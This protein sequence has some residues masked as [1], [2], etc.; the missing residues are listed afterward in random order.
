MKKIILL[1]LGAV[2]CA[3]SAH[4]AWVKLDATNFPDENF[5]AYLYAECKKQSGSKW[6]VNEN[7]YNAATNEINTDMIA[8]VHIDRQ[9]ATGPTASKQ[10]HGEKVAYQS[11]ASLEGIKLLTEVKTINLPTPTARVSA[12]KRLDV[13]GMPK[14]ATVTNG[15]K[16][17]GLSGQSP[18]TSGFSCPITEVLAENCPALKELRLSSYNSLTNLSFKGS[19]N[20][21]NLFVEYTSIPELDISELKN[22]FNE[23]SMGNISIGPSDFAAAMGITNFQ[24]KDVMVVFGLVGCK[25]LKK[26]TLGDVEIHHLNLDKCNKLEVLDLSGQKKLWELHMVLDLNSDTKKGALRDFDNMHSNVHSTPSI[27]LGSLKEVIFGQKDIIKEVVINGA[28]MEHIDLD[29]I[30]N[31]VVTLDLGTNRL[32]SVDL[33]RLAKAT[34]IKVG[35]NRIRKIALPKNKGIKTLDIAWNCLTTLPQFNGKYSLLSTYEQPFEILFI[36]SDTWRVRVFDNP[37]DAQY[38]IKETG[39]TIKGDSKHFFYYAPKFCRLGDP[40]KAEYDGNGNATG[41]MQNPCYVYFFNSDAD[42]DS[43]IPTTYPS[44]D[45]YY[46]FSNTFSTTATNRFNW[47]KIYFCRYDTPDSN[48]DIPLDME[49]YLAG[50]FNNWQPTEKDKFKLNDNV[51]LYYLEYGT[52]RIVERQFRVWGISKNGWKLDA[53]NELYPDIQSVSTAVKPGKNEKFYTIN[54]MVLDYGAHSSETTVYPGNSGHV[55][56]ETVVKHPLDTDKG[57][58]FTTWTTDESNPRFGYQGPAFTLKADGTN[59]PYNYLML[60]SGKVVGVDDITVD[61]ATDSNAPVEYY[62]LSGRRGAG[63]APGLY[64]RRQGS[65]VTKV[66]VR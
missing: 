4:A 55:Y 8:A 51:G 23:G 36:P 1:L 17:Y 37:D 18:A 11:I 10:Y 60:Y 41:R 31:T 27:P 22:L 53:T 47:M 30:C 66:V 19:K 38:F 5:R 16:H 56:C 13:S 3:L 2:W 20:I 61:A 63:T 25:E 48:T 15:A 52:D 65:A 50:D 34:T 59:S 64:I 62:D 7:A 58:H 54:D 14:L 33:T 46:Y 45:A 6:I 29:P 49:Y 24:V 57:L 40:T 9:D 28:P 39:G 44:G 35:N 42:A 43:G 21:R 32:K 12:L 26:L